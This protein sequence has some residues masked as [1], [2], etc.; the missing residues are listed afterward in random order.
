M[1]KRMRYRYRVLC[2]LCPYARGVKRYWVILFLFSAVTTGL[3]FATPRI[4]RTFIEHVILQADFGMFKTV[5]FGYLAVY[6]A[7]AA[8]GHIKA[9]AKYA[10][11]NG[12][13][14]RIRQKILRNFWEMRFSDYEKVSVGDLKMRIDEDT[15]Q[16]AAF[17]DSQTIELLMQYAAGVVSIWMLFRIHIGL[18]LFSMLAIPFTFWL[19]SLISR[20]EKKI[21]N[22]RREIAQR[23]S[24]WLHAFVQGWSEVRALNLAKHEERRYYRFLHADMRCNAKWINYW[25][26]RVLIIP[27]LKDEFFMQFGL[28][29]IGGLLILS[30]SL[31]IGDLLVFA[32]Y[33]ALLS[34][35]VQTVSAADADLQ[36]GMPYTDRLLESLAGWAPEEAYDKTSGQVQ[37]QPDGKKAAGQKR[38][39]VCGK[40]VGQVP[41]TSN[42]IVLKKVTFRYP[43]VENALFRNLDLTIEKGERVAVTGKSGSGK[44]TLLKLITGMLE[45]TSGS[46]SFSGIDLRHIDRTFMYERIGYI[47]QENILFHTTIRENLLFGKED[48]SEEEL[49][50]ACRKACIDAFITGLPDGFDTVIGEKGIKLSGGQRQR[51]VLAR[52]FLQDN[53]VFIFDEATSALDQYSENIV[54][55]AIRS[56]P[57][58]KTVIVAAH[59]ASSLKLCDR[60]IEVG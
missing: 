3:N 47:M 9:L 1:G 36:S 56:I 28:Y 16:A 10:L 55:D 18:A 53:D 30:G 14:Y 60:V 23:T 41:D 25:T 58:D 46:V 45:P 19:G 11:V 51:I 35:A 42:T 33:Y 52:M 43:D 32:M 39:Q 48:A 27:K 4:Y 20:C 26:A 15:V 7:D 31:H 5:V 12:T 22:E 8:A 54:Q 44:T 13:T 34:D 6:F 50:Q 2:G 29:F 38:E 59:R 37:E 49:L 17:A 57:G 40:K 24:S 21:T